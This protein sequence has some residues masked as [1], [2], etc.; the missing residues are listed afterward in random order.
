ML[1]PTAETLMISVMLNTKDPNI[2][3]AA[4]VRPQHF[5]SYRDEYEWV[6]RYFRE[7]GSAPTFEQLRSKFRG[8]PSDKL[9]QDPRQPARDMSRDY[10]RKV[11]MK[12]MR[13]AASALELDDVEQAYKLISG[14][15][16]ESFSP[17]PENLLA[18][19]D[20]LNDYDET[21]EVIK[22]PWPTLQATTG[23]FS[24]EQLVYFAARPS[25]GKSWFLVNIAAQ[26]AYEGYRVIFYSLE[27]SKREL[28][29]RSHAIIGNKIGWG[30]EIDTF[31]MLHKQYDKDDYSLLLRDLSEKT[32]GVLHIHDQTQGR[33][34]PS[35]VASRAEDYDLTVIDYVGLM[36]ADSG[37]K[38]VHDWRVAAE[39]SNDLKHIT[40]SKKSR[41]LAAAQINRDGEGTGNIPPKMRSMASTDVYVQDADTILTM[42]RL[43]GGHAAA[44]SIEK[45]RQGQD[46]VRFYTKFLA[47]RGDFSEV[48]RA[49]ADDICDELDD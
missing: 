23:G 8:F 37:A 32:E 4:G 38:S 12:S 6:N 30:S 17:M 16:L 31:K 44:L 9:I 35:V 40:R 45:N 20:F 15:S 48:T 5:T 26:A 33:V 24:P 2:V 29:V 10:A 11:L 18:T 27:M 14:L 1:R 13:E 21:H 42:T 47:N 7:Y 28:Q 25:Q 36:D 46:D 34:T 41:I 22:Y 19:D 43:R 49:E 3:A 39:I